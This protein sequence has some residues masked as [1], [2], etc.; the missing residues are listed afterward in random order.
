[1]R[2]WKYLNPIKPIPKREVINDEGDFV[3]CRMCKEETPQR[4]GN[5]R[6]CTRCH[7][8]VNSTR[9]MRQRSVKR[10]FKPDNGRPGFGWLEK[11][12]RQM[13]QWEPS[14]ARPGWMD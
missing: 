5:Q 10:G 3:I 9:K 11:A 13:G 4:A 14:S 6:Y 2:K 1:M 8:I 7:N 12:I